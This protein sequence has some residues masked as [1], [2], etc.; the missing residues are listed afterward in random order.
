VAKLSPVWKYS[1]IALLAFAVATLAIGLPGTCVAQGENENPSQDPPPEDPP[2]DPEPGYNGMTFGPVLTIA[3][4]RHVTAT[5]LRTLVA[6]IVAAIVA[7]AEDKVLTEGI[8]C[9][10]FSSL[11]QSLECKTYSGAAVPLNVRAAVEKSGILMKSEVS[12]MKLTPPE[13]QPEPEVKQ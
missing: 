6:P 2:P 3:S 13:P 5:Q 11:G 10:A 8:L 12:Q 4:S 7:D 1:S 9:V